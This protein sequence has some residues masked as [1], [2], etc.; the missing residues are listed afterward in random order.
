MNPCEAFKEGQIS[1][2]FYLSE[3][4]DHP[5]F[6]RSIHFKFEVGRIAVFCLKISFILKYYRNRFQNWYFAFYLVTNR[7]PVLFYFVY[8][9][10]TRT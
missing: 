10:P 1:K 6:R 8:V 7:V 2:N 4:R 3:E 9:E 5:Y